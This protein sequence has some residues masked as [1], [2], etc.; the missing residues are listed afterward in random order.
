MMPVSIY[1]SAP[2]FPADRSGPA[3]VLC[4]L[5]LHVRQ[6][7]ALADQHDHRHEHGEQWTHLSASHQRIAVL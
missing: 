3:V 6:P 1:D 2:Y 4:E 7:D 5:L